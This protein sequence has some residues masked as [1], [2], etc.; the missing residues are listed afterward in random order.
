[1]VNNGGGGGK[2]GGGGGESRD[3]DQSVEFKDPSKYPGGGGGEFK[4]SGPE[5]C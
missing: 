3:N 4:L 1:M 2:G 5:D